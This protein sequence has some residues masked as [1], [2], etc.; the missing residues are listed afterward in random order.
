MRKNVTK[1]SIVIPTLNE[2]KNIETVL[3]KIK[4]FFKQRGD[5]TYEII[6]VD[7]YSKDKT[8][9]I[10]KRN[11]CKALYDEFGKGSAL[12]KG[13]RAA[14]GE[15]IVTMDADVSQRPL[16]LGLLI[17]GIRAGYDIV[18]GSRFI[19][20]GGTEDMPWYRKIGNK[21]FVS[22]VNILWGTHY[23]DL[24]YGYRAF[25]NGVWKKLNL[26]SKSF[27]IEAEISIKAAK[28]KLNVLE[29]PSFEKRR[30]YGEGKLKTLKHGWIIL[31]TIL[32]EIFSD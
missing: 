8:V 17:E 4:D 28:R 2:E 13:M 15:I 30:L 23:T 7:G 16:E 6:V 24:C 29:V 32:N 3:M 25:R 31:K 12:I 5:Y 14:K 20:G 19:Q 18:M 22:L 11:G 10:A 9:E 1:V 26:K 27:G 21:F